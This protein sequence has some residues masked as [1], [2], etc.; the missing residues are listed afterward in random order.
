MRVCADRE[1]TEAQKKVTQMKNVM[2][3]KFTGDVEVQAE[4]FEAAL[5]ASEVY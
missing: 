2:S 3:Y 1:Y 4:Y 5:K